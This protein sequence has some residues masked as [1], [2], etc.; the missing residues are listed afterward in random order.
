MFCGH[1]QTKKM[2]EKSTETG[3]FM[4][5]QTISSKVLTT[6]EIFIFRR[7]FLFIQAWRLLRWI[8]HCENEIQAFSVRYANSNYYDNKH[9][10]DSNASLG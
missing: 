9:C 4:V 7:G 8:G 10:K 3:Q 6:A 5:M 1:F 2:N